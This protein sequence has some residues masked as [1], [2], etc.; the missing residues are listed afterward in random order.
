MYAVKFDGKAYK[1]SDQKLTQVPTNIILSEKSSSF[2]LGN[3]PGT[4][5]AT[6]PCQF[7]ESN[8]EFKEF[9]VIGF[10]NGR[11]YT[12]K[13]CTTLIPDNA[14]KEVSVYNTKTIFGYYG[15][16]DLNRTNPPE[17][18]VHQLEEGRKL[19]VCARKGQR[20]LVTAIVPDRHA[21]ARNITVD[22]VK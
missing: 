7:I 19:M 8:P 3:F 5:T 22:C 20:G 21:R 10:K 2:D 9:Y 13:T 17:S 6:T 1:S 12:A 4:Q 11:K 15:Q 18:I 16:F 14:R